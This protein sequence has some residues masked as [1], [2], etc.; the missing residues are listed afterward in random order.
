MNAPSNRPNPTL[1]SPP[2]AGGLS[3]PSDDVG[4]A[5]SAATT[6][7]WEGANTDPVP[8][9]P[10]DDDRVYLSHVSQPEG[11]QHDIEIRI[12]RYNL[13]RANDVRT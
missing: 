1:T 12:L 2:G 6:A 9:P 11:C 5:P 4:A 8:N 3:L 7:L 13:D 10:Q